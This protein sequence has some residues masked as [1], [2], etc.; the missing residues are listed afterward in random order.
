METVYVTAL[1]SHLPGDPVN[2]KEMEAYIGSRGPEARKLG[3]AVLRKNG[4]KTRH[5]AIE[6]D[7]S[8]ETTNADIAAQALKKAFAKSETDLGRLSYLATATTQG[9]YLVPGHGSAVHGA[10]GTRP[11][12]VASFQSVCASSAMA[13]KSAYLQLKTGEHEVAAVTASEFS[14]RWFRPGFYETSIASYEAYTPSFETE[15]LRWTLSDGGG[16]AVLETRPNEHGASLRVDWVD[17][18]SYADRFDP[19][20][21]AGSVSNAGAATKPWSHYGDP[22]AAA[23]VSA[24]QL[25]QDFELLYKMFPVWAGHYLDLVEAGRIDPASIDYFLP[26]Y[27]AKS[28]GEELKRLLARTGAMIPEERWFTNLASKGNTG[29]ASILIMLEEL[30]RTKDLKP[31]QKIL[32]FVPESGRAIISFIQFTVV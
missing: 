19:C 26:H 8:T 11:M 30:F 29:S 28:L 18:C 20:M 23:E 21:Y 31:G 24:L 7:G 12:E 25:K 5:Y 22:V 4:V 16:S 10:L 17:L 9:D 13:F 1:G 27:S 3:A 2:N 6:P 14:S 15:F 32:C